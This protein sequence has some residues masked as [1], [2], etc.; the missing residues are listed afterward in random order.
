MRNLARRDAGTPEVQFAAMGVSDPIGLEAWL[1]RVWRIVDDPT[2]AEFV[3]S[4][5]FQLRCGRFEGDCDD[6]AT[7]AASLLH[8]LMI[9]CQLVA[10]R[11]A[12]ESDFSHVFV[13]VPHYQL[14]I[15]PIIPAELLPPRFQEALTLDV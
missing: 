14:I 4:P 8:A 3:R 7:L 13:H 9:P 10:I 15:D 2:T 11:Q 6:A 1:R 12:G 5:Q